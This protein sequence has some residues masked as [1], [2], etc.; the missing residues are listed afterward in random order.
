MIPE[1]SLG[2]LRGHLE[3]YFTAI[4]RQQEADRPSLI[5]HFQALDAWQQ[6]HADEAPA[7]LRHYLQQKSYQKALAFLKGEAPDDGH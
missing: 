5:P 7:R 1:E 4:V 2:A 6:D 3:A